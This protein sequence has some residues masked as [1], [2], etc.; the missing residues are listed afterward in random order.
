M[1]I[2][3]ITNLCPHYRVNTFEV[4]AKYY[5][6]D[7]YFFSAG[8]EWY[9][10]QQH[11]LRQGN[12]RYQYLPGF[13]AGHARVTP[14][15]PWHLLS[16]DYTL[17]IKCIN[18]RFALPVTYQIAQLKRR[19]F[20]LWTGVW[21]RLQT[22]LHRAF[23]PFTR[24][25]YRHAT[26]IVVYGNHVKRYLM[27]EGVPEEKIFT[28]THAVDNR[29]YNQPVA[30]DKQ[31]ALRQELQVDEGQK[32]ILYLGRLEDGK[33][34]EYLLEAFSSL[35]NTDTVLVFVG[36]GSLRAKLEQMVVQ[37]NLRERVRFVGYIP[38]EQ[39][40]VCYSLAYLFVL[41]S[42]TT[43]IFKE[44]WGLVVNEAFNQGVPVIATDAVGAAAGGL[45]QDGHNGFVVPERNSQALAEAI[46]TLLSNPALREQ[47]SIHAKQ[48]IKTWDNEQMVLGFREAIS[49]VTAHH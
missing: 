37:E 16:Q 26:A 24:Y 7:Y 34:L 40:N 35:P 48:V 42:V 20:I 31:A 36:T 32:L 45:V 13:T 5:D 30:A 33:G 10:Q 27:A 14:T 41:P 47:F 12:F 44:P 18:G 17:Y 29:N 25:I 21:Q 43:P 8:T 38:P 4:L 22:P 28:T 23:F 9:W 3:F 46:K 11:G 2:A 49:Y 15:L 39:T 1:K 6:I 19:P